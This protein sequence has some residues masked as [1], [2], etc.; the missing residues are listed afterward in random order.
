MTHPL[1]RFGAAGSERISARKM[2]PTATRSF[3]QRL[4]HSSY[5]TLRNLMAV[6]LSAIDLGTSARMF[7]EGRSMTFMR[8]FLKRFTQSPYL[9]FSRSMQMCTSLWSSR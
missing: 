8:G 7:N 5:G 9:N 1:V 3:V 6:L 2:F 4:E